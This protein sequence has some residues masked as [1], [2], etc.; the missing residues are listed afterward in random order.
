MNT[1]KLAIQFTITLL[2]SVLLGACA[3]KLERGGPFEVYICGTDPKKD[4]IAK[5]G[6]T[7]EPNGKCT[8]TGSNGKTTS[9]DCQTASGV[10]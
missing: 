8:V 3:T 7:V 4:V 10:R 1:R 6:G 5:C 9:L 2:G